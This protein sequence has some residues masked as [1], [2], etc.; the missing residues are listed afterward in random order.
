MMK[1]NLDKGFD[2]DGMETLIK[3]GFA[4]P[5]QILQD[6]VNKEIDVLVYDAEIKENHSVVKK[7]VHQHRK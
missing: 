4:P 5:T 3:L 2:Q 6:H 7:G 1:A